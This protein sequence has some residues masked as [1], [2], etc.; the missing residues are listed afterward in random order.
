FYDPE[1]RLRLPKANVVVDVVDISENRCVTR[2]EADRTAR[3]PHRRKIG[4]QLRNEVADAPLVR[5]TFQIKERRNLCTG[6]YVSW[7][8]AERCCSERS[9]DGAMVCIEHDERVV[10]RG[11]V[12]R[13]VER[14][15]LDIVALTAGVEGFEV[16]LEHSAKRR[17]PNGVEGVDRLLRCGAEAC[18]AQAESFLKGRGCRPK[19]YGVGDRALS[20]LLH[21][22]TWIQPWNRNVKTVTAGPRGRRNSLV[23]VQ[24]R[25]P[26]RN[27]RQE[28]ALRRPV[29]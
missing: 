22:W 11:A 1:V 2:D 29:N 16:R 15:D 24:Q 27:S 18:R 26:Q 17:V 9:K 14:G 3:N 5:V 23:V 7:T 6:L 28:L 20:R 8:R 10:I 12:I 19:R 21:N 13:R 25:S 4:R